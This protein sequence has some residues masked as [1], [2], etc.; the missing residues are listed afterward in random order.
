[1]FKVEGIRKTGKRAGDR[2]F[3]Y[4]K[5][6]KKW[7]LKNKE[8]CLEYQARGQKKYHQKYPWASSYWNMVSRCTNPKSDRYR[9]Y[10]LRGIKCFMTIDEMGHLWFRDKAYLLKRPSIDRI[11]NDGDYTF[12]NCRFIELSENSRKGAKKT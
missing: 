12:Q 10:G 1:M 8:K 9:R 2:Y 7:R 6:E 11:N 5:R 3:W 4:P